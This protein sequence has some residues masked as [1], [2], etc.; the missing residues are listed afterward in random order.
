MKI[1]DIIDQGNH[2]DIPYL[3]V[4]QDN[5]SMLSEYQSIRKSMENMRK[6]QGVSWDV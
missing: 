2:L 6:M 5:T 4:E 1:Q 3:L